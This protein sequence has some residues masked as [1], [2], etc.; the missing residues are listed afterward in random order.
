MQF[1]PPHNSCPS[2]SYLLYEGF[3]HYEMESMQ[4]NPLSEWLCGRE[5]TDAWCAAVDSD[6]FQ[7]ELPS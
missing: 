2:L 4:N 6:L 3:L 1:F 5:S 7:T